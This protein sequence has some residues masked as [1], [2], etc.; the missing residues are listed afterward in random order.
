MEGCD[1]AA[2]TAF[3]QLAPFLREFV[4]RS[5]WVELRPVQVAAIRSILG[6]ED[7]VLITA[8]TASGK[9]EAA[10]LPILSLIHGR[11][12]GSVQAL[13]VGPLKA[14][15]N[16]QFQ[17]LDSVCEASGIPVHRWHGDVGKARKVDLL[18]N[19]GGVLQITPESIESLLVN[20][21][22]LLR[23]LFSGLRFVV[24]DEV[25]TFLESDRGVQLRSQLERLSAYVSG[26]RPRRVGLSATVGDVGTVTRWLNARRPEAVQV[27]NP[28]GLKLPV[29]MSHLHFTAKDNDVPQELVADLYTLT[30]DCKALIFC[31]SRSEVEIVTAMLNRLCQREGLDE[32]FLPHHGSI[33]M[34]VRE[35][36]ESR[37]RDTQR[38]SSVVCTSTLELGIDIGRLDLVV[39]INSTHTVTSFVQRLGRSGRREGEP[40]KVQIYT[41]ELERSLSALFYERIPFGML[42]AMAVTDLFL[43]GWIEPPILYSRPYNVLYHQILS[44]LTEIHGCRPI[45]LVR[46]FASTAL[47]PG[48]SLDDYATLLKH[49]ASIGHIEQMSDGELIVGLAGEKVVRAR[50]F[51]AVF[52][53][54]PEWDVLHGTR[55]LGR[56]TPTLDLRPEV[57]MLLG[58]HVWRVKEVLPHLKRVTV[59]PA[60][61]SHD[62]MFKS[63]CIPEMHPRIA[64][65]V[66]DILDRA[67]T[68]NYMSDAGL[69]ALAEARRRYHE[70]GMGSQYVYETDTNWIILPWSGTRA[71][72]TLVYLLVRTGYQ[73]ASPFGLFPWVIIVKREGDYETMCKAL[74]DEVAAGVHADSV[75][76][77]VPIEELTTH[78]YDEFLPTGLIRARAVEE[79]VDWSGALEVLNQITCNSSG[80]LSGLMPS[81]TLS[82]LET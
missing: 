56:I 81:T 65:R 47:F 60:R 79:W 55:N 49:L 9:T 3:D 25:H 34:E 72:R 37:M 51:Y 1:A 8:G 62:V 11:P 19:P 64:Q 41:T 66:R 15:I 29:R 36:A 4:Y 2:A 33:G 78:K 50:D 80:R 67:D 7:D 53:T 42:K 73:A 71:V 20:R 40:R 57:C 24:I 32:R 12:T 61:E 43:E 45:D 44:R 6:S 22:T 39:L 21:T 18:R 28:E 27:I 76:A 30:R 70:H 5:A 38:P 35:E 26:T 14:L 59:V 68:P 48:V 31:N 13:Y 75:V 82:H 69:R 46:F 54:S 74:A 77:T 16:D 52:Q 17:R 63:G 10:F 23:R 58:G